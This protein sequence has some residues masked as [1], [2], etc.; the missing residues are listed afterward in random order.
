MSEENNRD[1]NPVG[2]R[3]IS[4]PEPA[5]CMSPEH[6]LPLH[7]VLEPGTYEY[8]CPACGQKTT[9]VVLAIWF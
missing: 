4:G 9:F 3:K 8:T 5:P 6:N 1:A 2:L 7:I